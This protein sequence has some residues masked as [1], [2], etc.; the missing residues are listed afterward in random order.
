[1]ASDDHVHAVRALSRAARLL[2]H[3]SGD[4]TLA[5]Y[6]VLSAVAGGDARASRIAR[7]LALGKP[8]VSNAVE[9]LCQRGLLDRADSDDQ[10][11]VLLHLTAAG[12]RQL[13]AV[14]RDMSRWLDG[15]LA[16]TGDADRVL[17]ALVAF[18]EGIEALHAERAEAR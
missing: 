5:Q 8:A 15:V 18:G 16:R 14:E 2:E 10:R 11:V 1:M 13:N 9:A 4:L 3:A 6:R 17:R 12:R 7:R